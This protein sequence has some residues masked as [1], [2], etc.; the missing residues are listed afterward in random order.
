MNNKTS[1]NCYLV[2][3]R[4]EQ[5]Q[6]RTCIWVVERKAEQPS[7]DLITGVCDGSRLSKST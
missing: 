5:Q 7:P 4:I 2:N 1:T 3:E 6:R